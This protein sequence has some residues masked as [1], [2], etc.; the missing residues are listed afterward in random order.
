MVQRHGGE[1]ALP[2]ALVVGLGGGGLPVFLSR[3][4]GMDVESVEL[5]PVVVDLAQRHF[6]FSDTATLQASP[7][8]TA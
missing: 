2:R 4:C 3:H 5:D 8:A 6:G 1:A 7:A